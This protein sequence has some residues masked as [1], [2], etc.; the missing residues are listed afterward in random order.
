MSRLSIKGTVIGGIVDVVASS[1]LGIP[2]VVYAMVR[3]GALHLPREQAPMAV[4]ALIHA[5]LGL[6]AAQLVLGGLCSVLGGYLAAWIAKHDEMLN[7]AGSSFLCVAIGL[8]SLTAGK[9]PVDGFHIVLL[10]ASP[11]LGALGGYLRALRSSRNT[12]VAV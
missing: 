12:T 10:V 11:A 8:Y 7:G 5:D 9:T 1:L 2:L 3:V 4:T 6:R